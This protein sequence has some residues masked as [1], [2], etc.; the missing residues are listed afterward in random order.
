MTSG[1]FV[2]DSVNRLLGLGGVYIV[3]RN[4]QQMNLGMD[5]RGPHLFMIAVFSVCLFFTNSDNNICADEK[6][7]YIRSK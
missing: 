6:P 5:G 4:G 2:V 3:V 7:W 1:I